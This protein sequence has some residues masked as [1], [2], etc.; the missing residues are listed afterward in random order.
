MLKCSLGPKANRDQV[1][2]AGEGAGRSGS[3]FFFSHDNC[4][5]IKTMSSE[6]KGLYLRLL[7]KFQDHYIKNPDSTLARIF[8]VFTVRT[9]FMEE[10]HV[11]LMENTLR[12]KNPNKLQYVFDL[13]GSS[14]SR[15]VKGLTK[16]TTTL[17]DINFLQVAARKKMFVKFSPNNKNKLRKIIKKDVAF[18]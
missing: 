5:I 16:P 4:F 6:E 3:F 18:L 13:K 10:V 17:K 1:F 12:V 2:K 14:V 11:M 9:E 7:P 8:G 15:E